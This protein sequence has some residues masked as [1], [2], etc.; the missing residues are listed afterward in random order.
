[1]TRSTQPRSGFR[2]ARSI[3]RVMFSA[4]DQRRQQVERLEHEAEAVA[5]QA[6]ELLVGQAGEV[7]VA[8]EDP[9][10]T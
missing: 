8:D 5:P 3:G 7:D 2:P 1:M 9:A 4:A 10:R 6:G